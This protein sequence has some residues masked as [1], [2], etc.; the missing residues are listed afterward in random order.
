[1]VGLELMGTMVPL[2]KLPPPMNSLAPRLW[3]MFFEGVEGELDVGVCG[4]VVV[5]GAGVRLG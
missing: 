5:D 1:M 4:G 3:P 2:R